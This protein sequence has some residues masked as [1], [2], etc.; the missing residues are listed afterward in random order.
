MTNSSGYTLT[1]VPS[2]T[3][4]TCASVTVNPDGSFVATPSASTP[5][6][7]TF[8][9]N[10]STTTK[11][12]SAADGTVTVNF[13]TATGLVVNIKDALNGVAVTDYRWIIEED[14][15][16]WID[17]ACQ[18]NSADPKVRPSTCPPLPV[19]SLGYNFHTAS[20]PV[21]AQGCVGATSCEAGQTSGG[22]NVKCDLGNG[23]CEPG[24]S[25]PELSPSSV[26]LDPTKRYFISILPGDGVNPTIGGAGG[27]MQVDPNCDATTTTCAMRKFDIAKDCGAFDPT[28]DAWAP[29]GPNSLCGHEMGG[30]QI[31]PGQT[32]VTVNL[33][34]I[35]LPPAK[36]SAFVFEDDNPLN[37]ENDAGGGVDV[38]APNEP[39][40]GGFEI[41]LFDQAGGLGDN[42]GQP[43]YDEFNQPLSN[44]LAG[45]IDPMTGMDA[46]PITARKDRL[47]GMIP[48]CP[49]FES[50][51][52]TYS[53]L[54]G[55][56]VIDNLYAGLYEVQAYPG[57]DRIA[58]G[59]NWLQTNTLDGGAP[60][61][62]FLKPNEPGY[63]QEFGPGN[64]HVTIGFANPAIINARK[65]GYCASAI[66]NLGACNHTLTVHVT[67]NHMS[68]APDERTYSSGTYD[69]Y[70]FT[71]C[72]VSVGPAD[73]EDFAFGTCD[74]NGTVTLTGMPA[75]TFKIAVFDQ[76]NDIMLDGLVGTVTVD[77]AKPATDIEFPVTQW[78][79]DLSTHT[80]VDTNANGLPDDGEPGLALVNTNIRYRDGSFGFFNNTDLGGDA[81][82]NEVFPF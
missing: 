57:A 68:R 14:R 72:Y 40:L 8:N 20:M 34:E 60:H 9:Y 48:T 16:F 66:N 78:R 11:Q 24:A 47:V 6:S 59:E 36:L 23:G 17:P 51:G 75:G 67:N 63:F 46:C 25:K 2:A 4:G 7:C 77:Q 54:A 61:E 27:A 45:Y 35:P 71:T 26:Y 65:A 73:A 43:T 58:R 53:P 80:F 18:V 28:Q 41:K 22:Q 15:T 50:D 38:L 29:G 69:H 81:G 37:G 12:V 10:V 5:A 64:F 33:Q 70:S 19:E 56:V 55:Q 30:A 13:P 44:S 42:T 74:S 49:T 32:T 62:V 39:G 76:W 82:F 31:A 1:A 21:V 52:K 79:T 3:A